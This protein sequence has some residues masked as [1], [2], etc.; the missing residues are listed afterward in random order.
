MKTDDCFSEGLLKKITAGKQE[1]D[2]SQYGGGTCSKEAAEQATKDAKELL[3]IAE[4][5][6]AASK[7]S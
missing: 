2:N 7:T 4:K 3:A 5:L 1:V 6:L